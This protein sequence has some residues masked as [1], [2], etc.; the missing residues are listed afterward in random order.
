[1]GETDGGMDPGL[2]GGVATT[3]GSLAFGLTQRGSR[4]MQVVVPLVVVPLVVVPVV[5]LPVVVA[6]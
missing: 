5:V 2:D 1:M 3:A 4:I 6:K